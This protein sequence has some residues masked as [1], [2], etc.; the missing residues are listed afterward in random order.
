[1]VKRTAAFLVSPQAWW[2]AAGVWFTGTMLFIVSIPAGLG[3]ITHEGSQVGYIW[4][5]NWSL[6]FTIVVP[7]IACAGLAMIRLMWTLPDTLV[8]Y[9]MIYDDRSG[10]IVADADAVR[11]AWARHFHRAV[12]LALIFSVPAAIVYSVVDWWANSLAPTLSETLPEGTEPDWAVAPH[13]TE[14]SAAVSLAFSF[15]GYTVQAVAIVCGLVLL[16]TILMF[17]ALMLSLGAGLYGG[18]V[19]IADV[20]DRGDA[21]LGFE[22]FETIG[23]LI[24]IVGYL[25]FVALYFTILQNQYLDQLTSGAEPRP[26]SV[27]SQVS[28]GFLASTREDGLFEVLTEFRWPVDSGQPAM[29]LALSTLIVT[30][31]VVPLFTFLL[32]ATRA[33][34]R[35]RD[36]TNS[37]TFESTFG[38]SPEDARA[39]LGRMKIWPNGWVSQTWVVASL[40]VCCAALFFPL[41]APYLYAS[42]LVIVVGHVLFVVRRRF[43]GGAGGAE[44]A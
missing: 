43:P 7:L 15:V 44:R 28:P 35:T 13:I 16:M 37:D 10:Q 2:L 3:N 6:N 14:V 8:R 25:T 5:P 27:V 26:A 22:A 9:R 34:S 33:R 19:L 12:L 11:R 42:I 40:M 41:L 31:G 32:A 24:L 29:L 38:V 21:R 18:P 30:F 23:T 39:R 17:G 36:L 20:R 4:A 1:M